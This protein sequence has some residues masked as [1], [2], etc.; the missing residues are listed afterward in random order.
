[1]TVY[2]DP[3]A[4]SA[5]GRLWSHL[6]SDTSYEELHAFARG[7]GI[8]ERGFDRDHYDVPQERYDDIVA[9]GAVPA[10]SRELVAHLHHSGL[11]RRKRSRRA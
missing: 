3:P 1:M 5:H 7:L 2:V 8:P 4:W 11:R 6:V 10:S 9:A